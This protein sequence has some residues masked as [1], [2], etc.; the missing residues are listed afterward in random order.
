MFGIYPLKK[1]RITKFLSGISLITYLS[2]VLF[3]YVLSVFLCA[4]IYFQNSFLQYSSNQNVVNVFYDCLYFSVITQT[5]IGYGDILPTG[6]GRLVVSLQALYGTIYLAIA[7]G[8]YLLRFTWTNDVVRVSEVIAFSPDEKVFRVRI[9]NMSAFD[10]HNIN[11]GLWEN[12]KKT[13]EYLS[14]K[15]IDL[16]YTNILSISSMSPWKIKTL[17]IDSDR[18]ESI[19]QNIRKFYFQIDG[20]YTNTNYISTFKI[21]RENIVCG[22]FERLKNKNLKPKDF[23]KYKW[24]NFD[25]VLPARQLL[26]KCE[27]CQFWRSCICRNKAI[28][29]IQL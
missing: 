13:E 10:I 22:N 11:L 8:L 26:D 12:S 23:K 21:D 17:P 9:I 6:L 19:F 16:L 7:M 14:N 25:L 20:K 28:E 3:F 1:Y 24:E 27:S 18:I 5:T 15:P 29:N 2:F 4:Y